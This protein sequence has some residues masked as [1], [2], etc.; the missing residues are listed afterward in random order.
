[1][2]YVAI[3][4]VI[5]CNDYESIL[6]LFI[7]RSA[8]KQ[9]ICIVIILIFALFIERHDSLQWVGGSSLLT[10]RFSPGCSYS[11]GTIFVVGGNEGSSENYTA[12]KRLESFNIAANQWNSLSST[13]L[14]HGSASVTINNLLYAVGGTLDSPSNVV[15]VYNI[16]G[17]LWSRLPN[18]NL[19][20]GENRGFLQY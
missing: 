17:G 12:S 20:R 4:I 6:S 16:T 15:E 1:M 5:H 7:L 9:S 3:L 13:N 8:M 18:M 19:S 10:G 2:T 11:N 14:S